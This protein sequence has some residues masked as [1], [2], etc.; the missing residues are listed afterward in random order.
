VP[1]EP[2]W[3]SLA[4]ERT[5]LEKAAHPV[6]PRILDSFVDGG[7][8]YL[9]E[10]LPAGQL[11]WDAWDDPDATAEQRFGWLD[12]VAEALQCLHQGGSMLEGLRPDI[13]VLTPGGQPRLTDLAD[14]LPLP[15]PPHAPIRASHY[16]APELVLSADKVDARADLYSFGAMLYALHLGRELTEM[17][18]ELQ[19]VPK[20]IMERFPDVHPLFARLV[21][22]TFCRS[23]EARFPTEETAKTDPTGFAELRSTLEQCR[24]TLDQVRLDLA[25][26]TTTGMVRTSNEDAFALLH[27]VDGRENLL[28][29]TALIFLA[30]GMGGSEAG[31]IAA[32]L[33]IG[34]MREYL[35]QQPLFAALAGKSTPNSS[36]QEPAQASGTSFDVEACKALLTAALKEANKQVFDASRN[37]VGRRGMGCT[38][39]VVYLAGQHLVVGHVGDSR[40]YHLHRGRLTQVTTDH[41]WVNRM[42]Q[43]GALTPEE[44]ENHPRRSELQQAIGGYA[45]VEPSLYYSTLKPGDWVLVCTDGV[46]NHAAPDTLQEMLQSSPSAEAAA[47]QLINYVNLRGATDNATVVVIRAS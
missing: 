19:G 37:G 47:R 45:E 46:T 30:D 38:G 9:V 7:F 4:W 42:V 18:F 25:A 5:V 3:P 6:L 43:I 12:Q 24:R 20:S 1:L 29:D 32:A 14:L 17:D 36:T 10:E 23:P 26:W 33:A 28:G 35:L 15:L 41:T 39:E 34:A 44:A 40:T 31:E 16:A 22:K 2:N 13:V 27:A 21:C 8:E 11:L